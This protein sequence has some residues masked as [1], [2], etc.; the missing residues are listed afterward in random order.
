MQNFLHF[1]QGKINLMF[2]SPYRE[3]VLLGN[4]L[5]FHSFEPAR[6]KYFTPLLRHLFQN[7]MNKEHDIPA[8]DVF[9]YILQTR[10]LIN[11]GFII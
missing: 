11:E 2:N 8:I 3:S 9:I 7:K 4:L 10:N 6:L 1:A 5:V